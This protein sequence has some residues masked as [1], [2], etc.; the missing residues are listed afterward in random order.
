MSLI[1]IMRNGTTSTEVLEVL[2]WK[3]E[4]DRS[5]NQ[6]FTITEKDSSLLSVPRKVQPGNQLAVVSADLCAALH[7]WSARLLLRRRP[8]DRQQSVLIV[9]L[10]VCLDMAG[11]RGKA[12]GTAECQVSLPPA[13][14]PQDAACQP[15]TLTSEFTPRTDLAVHFNRLWKLEVLCTSAGVSQYSHWEYEIF[16]TPTFPPHTRGFF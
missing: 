5:Q 3:K 4:W 6:N 2:R 8:V 15:H 7:L 11:W 13:G 14:E 12:Q 10:W 1:L 16:P 9:S